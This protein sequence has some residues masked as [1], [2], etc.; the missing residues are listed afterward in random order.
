MRRSP[1]Q[2]YALVF[3]LA[4]AAAG[5]AGFLYSGNFSTGDAA[6][7]PA[8]RDAVLGVLDVNGW[9]NLVHLASG[10][11]GLAVAGSYSAAR[12]YALLLGSVYVAVAILGGIAGDGGAILGLI[13][14]NTEDTMLHAL[15]AATGLAAGLATPAAPPPTPAPRAA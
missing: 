9:H 2:T 6:S 15:I 11:L 5:A 10:L 4:L 14:V 7:D 12:V 1:A 3:G 8:N 13:P